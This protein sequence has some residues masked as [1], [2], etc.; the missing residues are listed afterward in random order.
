MSVN[1]S[2]CILN[3]SNCSFGVTYCWIRAYDR[4][5]GTKVQR[6]AGSIVSWYLSYSHPTR[7]NV[8]SLATA[9]LFFSVM[10]LMLSLAV[11]NWIPFIVTWVNVLDGEGKRWQKTFLIVKEFQDMI[12]DNQQR[13]SVS[14]YDPKLSLIEEELYVPLVETFASCNSRVQ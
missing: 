14:Y 11:A 13:N 5:A 8:R 9:T 12:F 3:N 7:G 2:W 6:G 10:I 1:F 4:P